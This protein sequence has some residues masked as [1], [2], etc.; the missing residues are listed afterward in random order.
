[1]TFARS[2]PHCPSCHQFS[3]TR[4]F[5]A[6]CGL[7]NQHPE[8]GAF[9]ASRWRRLGGAIL[10][11]ILFIVTL[12]IGWFVWLYFA[13]KKS[14]TP[15]KQLLGMY[16]L[17]R[18]GAPAS[19]GRVWL[20][21]VVVEMIGFGLAS[22][23]LFGLASLLDAV[24]IL[25][26]KDRQTLHDKIVDTIVVHP[27]STWDQSRIDRM[28]EAAHPIAQAGASSVTT[29]QDRLRE[30]RDLADQGLITAMEYEERRRHILDD[31]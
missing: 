21:E 14:Q 3:G 25:W 30:L 1:M 8:S 17:Q 7:L 13:S 10:E 16:I 23:F 15:A 12:I 26:D 27:V 18:N 2:Q 29:T 5:C 19:A 4:I 20:R 6:T 9:A 28:R 11:G 24:W 22:Q 31:V